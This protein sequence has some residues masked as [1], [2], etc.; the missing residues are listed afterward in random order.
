MLSFASG[1]RK[2]IKPQLANFRYLGPL[3]KAYTRG[4]SPPKNPDPSRWASGL[5]AWDELQTTAANNDEYIEDVSE[6]LSAPERL[7]T[8]YSLKLQ[9]YKELDVSSDLWT[10][11][12]NA[13]NSKEIRDSLENLKVSQRLFII[14]PDGL[15][16]RPYDVGAGISQ[17]IPVVAT[18]LISKSDSD[19]NLVGIEQPE[20]HLHPKI[21]ARLG[22]LFIHGLQG[23]H[24]REFIIETH[25]EHLMLRLLRRIRETTEGT[26]PVGHPGLK[27]EEVVVAYVYKKDDRTIV[28]RLRIDESGDF[29]NRWPEGF[30]DERL[31]ELF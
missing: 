27:P 30:F 23:R 24:S 3:R 2:T 7:D 16:L 10:K 11:L 17:V 28:K 4:D 8:G 14:S 9:R 29:I 26:L 5:G 12:V 6:W 22:D 20:L 18:A 21:E 13:N 25:S 19:V 15:E 1:P 31:D